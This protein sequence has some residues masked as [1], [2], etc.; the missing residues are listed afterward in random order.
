MSNDRR[1]F[2]RIEDRVCLQ[3]RTINPA[4]LDAKLEEFWS[5]RHQLSAHNEF[6]SRLDEQLADLHAIQN[7][8]PELARYL[9][10]MQEQID[11]LSEKL[12][13]EQKAIGGKEI[14]VNMSAQGISFITDE[15]FKP[16]DIV[17]LSLKL[18]PSRQAMTIFARVVL[19]EDHEDNDETDETDEYGQYRV[20]MD[21]EHIH[22]ADRETLVKHVHGKQ[23]R[24]L[25]TERNGNLQSR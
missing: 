15:L 24:A 10:V 6:N 11:R 7:K 22:E 23:F 4:E 5:N 13:P 16:V 3:T 21:F 18:Q 12:L 2:F 14:R 20:S 1:R 8:M 25:N 17:E 9:N 19:V